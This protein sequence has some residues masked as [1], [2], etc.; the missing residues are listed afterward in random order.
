[1]VCCQ[2]FSTVVTLTR[3]QN[4]FHKP[5][6]SAIPSSV[7][8]LQNNSQNTLDTESSDDISSSSS[9]TTETSSGSSIQSFVSWNDPSEAEDF[10][11]V[12]HSPSQYIHLPEEEELPY[13]E[14]YDLILKASLK[15]G[16]SWR[17][18]E[19]WLFLLSSFDS[20]VP[21]RYKPIYDY[22]QRIKRTIFGSHSTYISIG[23]HDI[24]I[25]DIATIAAM[26]LG[27][28]HANRPPEETM[29][30]P[31]EL[32]HTRAFYDMLREP[33]VP[34]D[35]ICI[36]LILFI[37][38]YK[39]QR[40]GGKSMTA[41]YGDFA[42]L[43]YSK[44]KPFD[45][46]H[47]TTDLTQEQQNLLITRIYA[48]LSGI[49]F[50]K[51][52]SDGGETQRFTI[53]PFAIFSDLPQRFSMLGTEG[54]SS[55]HHSCCHCIAST[56]ELKEIF[57]QTIPLRSEPTVFDHLF[58]GP[59]RRYF[60]T[61]I[62]HILYL[63]LIKRFF[64][65]IVLTSE[66]WDHERIVAV[67]VQG[68]KQAIDQLVAHLDFCIPQRYKCRTKPQL[69]KADKGFRAVDWLFLVNLVPSLG[70][71]LSDQFAVLWSL[72]IAT[73]AALSAP[74]LFNPS[75][76]SNLYY[77]LNSKWQRCFG[78]IAKGQLVMLPNLHALGH[79]LDS[80]QYFG[81]P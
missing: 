48:S 11:N 59:S 58:R 17:D 36:G 54:T 28:F 32:F 45:V 47:A 38:D 39:M 22:G 63:G 72:L 80:I 24:F 40:F 51:T 37:D 29:S 55:F 75:L 26:Q 53:R 5:N 16:S 20:R 60:V 81:P 1:M 50:T 10:D 49:I 30:H 14:I 25:T 56:P 74:D 13:D 33:C 2:S 3:H 44:R 62:M 79:L 35:V 69:N 78:V 41:I 4:R 21:I 64:E 67:N 70:T 27:E 65:D 9:N 73:T 52:S 18:C 71:L 6:T 66:A 43:P 7:L 42:N 46:A 34:D 61:D 31:T 68:R 12:N 19:I 57:W 15:T 77:R 8:A 76:L 23:E